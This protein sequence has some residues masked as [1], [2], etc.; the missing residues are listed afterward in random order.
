MNDN[1]IKLEQVLKYLEINLKLYEENKENDKLKDCWHD[2][3]VIAGQ[4][5]FA[6]IAINEVLKDFTK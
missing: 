2:S 3:A 1:I 6:I 5:Q 4:T